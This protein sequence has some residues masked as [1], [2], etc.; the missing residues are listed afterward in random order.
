MMMRAY[1]ILVVCFLIAGCNNNL[2]VQPA[3]EPIVQEETALETC[4]QHG[5]ECAEP[6]DICRGIHFELGLNVSDCPGRC[7]VCC[8]QIIQECVPDACCH[9]RGCILAQ[10]EL[11]CEGI[12]CTEECVEGT[13][14]CGQGWCE[15]D[16]QE[17]NYC[18]VVI[19]DGET[20]EVA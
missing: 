15:F 12:V 8:K 5:G 6:G 20:D 10:S 11:D 9:A 16:S 7:C 19:V 4:E 3:E 2:I 17:P 14:D 18:K 13:L 1:I